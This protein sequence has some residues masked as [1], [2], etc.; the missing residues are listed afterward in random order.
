LASFRAA[1]VPIHRIRPA[2]E[3]LEQRLGIARAPAPEQLY[4]DGGEVLCKR[5]FD[6]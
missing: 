1:D 4:T 2:V 3:A 5:F 6:S